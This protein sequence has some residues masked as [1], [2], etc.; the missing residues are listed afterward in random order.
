MGQGEERGQGQGEAQGRAR[1][2]GHQQPQ[3]QHR[4]G[5]PGFQTRQTQAGEAEQ[6]T[7]QQAGEEGQGH[8]QACRAPLLGGPEADGEQRQQMV[9]AEQRVG[10]A[11]QQAAGVVAGVGERQGRGQQQREG[12][13][14][15]V[16]PHK[17]LLVGLCSGCVQQAL[18]FDKGDDRLQSLAGF[19]VAEDEGLVAAHLQGV[20]LHHLQGRT[21][22]R[23][24]VD[25][26]DHQ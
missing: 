19:L 11:G 3:G 1:R 7:Q 17:N 8:G 24:Q 16:K 5:D 13:Q 2:Q 23:R 25:L 21:D 6:A 20:A 18:A 12:E 22:Q 26:V 14:W 10:Q 4:A 15:G 9:E